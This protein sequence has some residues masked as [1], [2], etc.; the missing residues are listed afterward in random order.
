MQRSE[1]YGSKFKSLSS[2]GVDD[3]YWVVSEKSSLY[4]YAQHIG[5]SDII[6]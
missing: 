2:V 4:G 1:D 6:Q 5:G 3:F